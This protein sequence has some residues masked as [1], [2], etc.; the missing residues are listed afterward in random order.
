M[1]VTLRTMLSWMDGTLSPEEHDRFVDRLGRSGSAKKFEAR[2][3]EA[4]GGD[5]VALLRVDAWGTADD[6]NQVAEY[7]DDRLPAEQFKRFERHCL[8]SD[9]HLAEVG[10]CHALLAER[11]DA[12]TVDADHGRDVLRKLKQRGRQMLPPAVRGAE[13]SIA[14]ASSGPPTGAALGG[15]PFAA[16]TPPSGPQRAGETSANAASLALDQL[17]RMMAQSHAAAAAAAMP[18]P[19]ETPPSSL[20]P[21]PHAAPVHAPQ[22]SIE[23]S[24][25]AWSRWGWSWWWSDDAEP[26][27]ADDEASPGTPWSE[28][29][30]AT[31]SCLAVLAVAGYFVMRANAPGTGAGPQRA[32]VHGQVTLNGKPLDTGMIVLVPAGDTKGPSAGATLTGGTFRIAAAG[33][34]V[35]GRYRVEIKANRKTGRMVKPRSPVGKS[36]QVEEVEQ[37]VPSRYNTASELE[38]EIK[39]GRNRVTFDL[40]SPPQSRIDLKPT[41]PRVVSGRPGAAPGAAP[42]PAAAKRRAG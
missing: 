6:A 30:M 16:A 38:I 24:D 15:K 31:G 1:E 28:R 35:V 23:S 13:T 20:S 21:D 27:E 5:A 14:S 25:G 33:G 42:A 41:G 18:R 34:P 9:A 19:G 36:K 37:V 32:A 29:L 17:A 7:L 3:R 40:T 22:P 26:A 10:A 39:P 4:V 8:E 11:A 12:V 2:I